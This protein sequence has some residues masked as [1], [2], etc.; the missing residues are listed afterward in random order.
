VV[1][2]HPRL[3][4]HAHK[5]ASKN[6]LRQENGGKCPALQIVLRILQFAPRPNLPPSSCFALT[7]APAS[8]LDLPET[9]LKSLNNRFPCWQSRV[10]CAHAALPTA[11]PKMAAAIFG[12][13]LT[14]AP[15]RI[16]RFVRK[17]CFY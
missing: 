9:I 10:R 11:Q 6:K 15:K 13:G 8:A 4:Y 5:F 16:H 7:P 17:S 1:V 2:A 12:F 3:F 14:L